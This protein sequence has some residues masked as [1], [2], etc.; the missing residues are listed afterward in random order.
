MRGEGPPPGL[1]RARR[2]ERAFVSTAQALRFGTPAL[3]RVRGPSCSK[4]R[5]SFPLFKEQVLPYVAVNP[6]MPGNVNS[7]VAP[8]SMSTTGR[9]S[10]APFMIS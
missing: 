4:V 6:V 1:R 3:G 2:R 7:I 8:Y 9:T 10:G 5:S